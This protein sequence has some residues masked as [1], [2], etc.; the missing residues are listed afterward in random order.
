MKRT[1]GTAGR[2]KH[3]SKGEWV[4]DMRVVL[5]ALVVLLIAALFWF[6]PWQ[7]APMQGASLFSAPSTVPTFLPSAFPP[8][9]LPY[10]DE[11]PATVEGQLEV[12]RMPG[13]NESYDV[14]AKVAACMNRSVVAVTPVRD[15]NGCIVDV[16]C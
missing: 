10:Q 2:G 3:E 1:A 16:T 14:S 4:M 15:G 11:S 12:L 7:Q 6:K 5:A 13:C 8:S 9:G